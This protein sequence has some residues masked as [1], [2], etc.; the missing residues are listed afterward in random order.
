MNMDIRQLTPAIGAHVSGIDLN[1]TPDAATLAVLQDVLLEHQV[2]FFRQ[3][4]IKPEAQRD[5]AAALGELHIHPVFP[6]HK[7]VREL[8][9]LDSHLLDLKDNEL[10]HTDVTFLEKPAMGCVL[11]AVQVPP[12]GGDTLWA[13]LTW[14]YDDL[15][16]SLQ[17]FLSGLTAEHDISLSFPDSRFAQTGEAKAALEKARR[18]FP[19]RRHPLVR[20]HPV[21]GKK[22]LF[23]TAG[24]TSR[25]CE[26]SPEESDTLLTFLFKHSTQPKYFVRW[27]WQNGDVAVWDNRCT[28]HLAS[29]D[30]GDFHRIMHRATVMGDK[31]V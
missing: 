23:V 29:F 4:Y 2:L 30:Y 18:D 24:F 15:S 12:F 21:T 16:P 26:L 27:H 13:S 1:L 22:G 31:P 11:S 14:A 17:E 10:W 20:T 5:F 9:V 3:Q 25:I 19:P 28:Q 6:S 8:I 7:N